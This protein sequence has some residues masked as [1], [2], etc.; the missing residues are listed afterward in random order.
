MD[1]DSTLNDPD[2][3][4]H[5]SGHDNGHFRDPIYGSDSEDSPVRNPDPN[6]VNLATPN[7]DNLGSNPTGDVRG[8]VLELRN[9]FQKE[10]GSLRQ[11]MNVRM[12]SRQTDPLPAFKFEGHRHQFCFNSKVLKFVQDAQDAISSKR[13]ADAILSLNE[14]VDTIAERQKQ[15][16]IADSSPG[17]WDTVRELIG[18]TDL[19]DDPKEAKAIKSAE[20]RALANKKS[21][22]TSTRPRQQPYPNERPPQQPFRFA[23]VD[24]IFGYPQQSA[25]GYS[26]PLPQLI[27]TGGQGGIRPNYGVPI[28]QDRRLQMCY[29]CGN[30]GHW[31]SQ[32]PLK[33]APQPA[34]NS[35]YQQPFSGFE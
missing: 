18:S 27:R 12:S 8:V 2:Y 4:A 15:I 14:A 11:D 23:P 20:A 22:P 1:S 24:G 13:S 10:I 34:P 31:R 19:T 32:C 6:S 35:Q 7:P 21:R 25:P 30:T 17:G 29:G 28:S 3:V 33:A 5:R 26:R 16:R 9:F